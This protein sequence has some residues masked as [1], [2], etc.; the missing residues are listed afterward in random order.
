M[1]SFLF[2]AVNRDGKS[3]TERVEAENLAQARYKLEIQ[4]HS[5][6]SF[7]ESELSNDTLNLFE[8]N[9]VKNRH[10]FL[11]QQVGLQY[12]TRLRRTFLT[13]FKATFFIWIISFYNIYTSR[14]LTSV[15]WLG[16]A[17]A[18]IGYFMIPSVIFN[19][20]HEAHCWAK[21][22]KVRFW[23]TAA[24]Y[25]NLIA[26]IKIPISRIDYY[27]ACADAH[28]GNLNG[29]LAKIAKYETDAKV[30][31]RIFYTYVNGVYACAKRFDENL[32]SQENSLREGNVFQEEMLDYATALARRH[33]KTSQARAVLNRVLDGE[34]TALA[35]PFIPFCQG[36]IEVEDGNFSQAE[37]YLQQAHKEIEPFEKNTY[38]VGLRSEIK[39]FLAITLG[40]CGEKEEAAKLFHEAKPYLLANRETELLQRCEEAIN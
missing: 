10:Q 5:E 28:E 18:V 33:K 2:T 21:N 23:A 32:Q 25:F 11:K 31:R 20:L 9:E 26:F 14:S 13:V 17:A 4:N 36:V 24:K 7:Y 6:I 38:L 34:I 15:L 35:R 1:P 8:K 29:A 19:L 22:E 27:F 3:I 40:T 30:S 12:D 16:G 37:F 39:A